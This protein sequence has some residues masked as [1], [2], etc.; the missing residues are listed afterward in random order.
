[1]ILGS[2]ATLALAAALVLVVSNLTLVV[3]G[4]P[5]LAVVFGVMP[6]VFFGVGM[7][8]SRRSTEELASTSRIP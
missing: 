6:L 4:S 5:T 7:L 1:V 2:F 8:L 3:G